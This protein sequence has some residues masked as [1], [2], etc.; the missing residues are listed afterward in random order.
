M[1]TPAGIG[2]PPGEMLS[3]AAGCRALVSG[4]PFRRSQCTPPALGL[5][6]AGFTSPF[7][8]PGSEVKLRPLPRRRTVTAHALEPEGLVVACRQLL[9]LCLQR[10]A[11][12]AH[13]QNAGLRL[14]HQ[15]LAAARRHPQAPEDLCPAL[16]RGQRRRGSKHC[17]RRALRDCAGVRSRPR[18]RAAALAETVLGFLGKERLELELEVIGRGPSAEGLLARP[19]SSRVDAPRLLGPR[20]RRRV[21]LPPG[22]I[23]ATPPPVSRGARPWDRQHLIQRRPL[24]VRPGSRPADRVRV[25]DLRNARSHWLN[26]G[27]CP[28]G[29][30]CGANAAGTDGAQLQGCRRAFRGLWLQ[31]LCLGAFL[32]I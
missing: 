31:P 15:S 2:H 14:C 26:G 16:A 6:A 29:G 23:P 10:P 13:L 30:G 12:V 24:S 7:Q 22:P 21:P 9:H 19:N 28:S 5:L 20:R 27:R 17:A 4:S 18:V 1:V 32:C 3:L 8:A 11:S 25:L